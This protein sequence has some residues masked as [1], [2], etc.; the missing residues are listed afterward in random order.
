MFS[1]SSSSSLFM[2][3]RLMPWSCSFMAT[4]FYGSGNRNSSRSMTAS[5][6][7]NDSMYMRGYGG[8]S[9]VGFASA[10]ELLGE[11]INVTRSGG[12]NFSF[13]YGKHTFALFPLMNLI[14]AV[15]KKKY[16]QD[17][18][19][20]GD[21]GG[22]APIIQEN[23]EGLELLKTAIAKAGY[24]GKVSLFQWNTYLSFQE[25][26]DSETF[27]EIPQGNPMQEYLQPKSVF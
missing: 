14:G 5:R 20:V 24:T 2:N 11:P 25:E 7:Q 21:E 17:A 19:N 16:G 9:L 3:G 23:K 22:F 26:A 15:I 13:G 12:N 8:W 18:T 10:N 27:E 6:H 4:S 1:S